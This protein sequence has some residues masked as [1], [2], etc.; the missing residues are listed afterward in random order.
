MEKQY[1]TPCN[2]RQAREAW[3]RYYKKEPREEKIKRLTDQLHRAAEDC[4]VDW[5]PTE[6]SRQEWEEYAE[7]CRE[8][9]RQLI[10]LGVTL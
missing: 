10:E 8:I 7:K 2:I 3:D 9:E 1:V 4:P 6:Q 5:A